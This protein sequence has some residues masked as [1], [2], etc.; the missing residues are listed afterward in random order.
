MTT[1]YINIHKDYK[2]LRGQETNFKSETMPYHNP[3]TD[4]FTVLLSLLINNEEV[5]GQMW[6]KIV[7][8]SLQLFGAWPTILPQTLKF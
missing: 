7:E 8:A 5:P 6:K 1:R 3:S 4:S 2:T